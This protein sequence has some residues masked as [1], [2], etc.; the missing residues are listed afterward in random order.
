MVVCGTTHISGN[1]RCEVEL[2]T[3]LN[4]GQHVVEEFPDDEPTRR[5]RES[6]GKASSSATAMEKAGEQSCR[7]RVRRSETT[8]E[9]DREVSKRD[10]EI[11]PEAGPGKGRSRRHYQSRC[12]TPSRSMTKSTGTAAVARSGMIAYQIV[13]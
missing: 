5:C 4:A 7:E 3:H 9:T 1:D 2:E 6:T 8:E 13:L 11:E 12:S 10:Q